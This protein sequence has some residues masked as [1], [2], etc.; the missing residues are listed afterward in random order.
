[1][2]RVM[3][4]DHT[5]GCRVAAR[6]SAATSQNLLLLQLADE[7]CSGNPLASEE[8]FTT[9]EDPEKM[10][11][12]P[13]QWYDRA[14]V[15]FAVAVGRALARQTR[16]HQVDATKWLSPVL[17][18]SARLKSG[19]TLPWAKDIRAMLPHQQ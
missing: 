16:K 4:T 8:W 12:T 14:A 17:T 15:D 19:E 9:A 1:M 3:L 18:T 6:Y 5:R 10:H 11:L 13:Q 2:L 7:Y